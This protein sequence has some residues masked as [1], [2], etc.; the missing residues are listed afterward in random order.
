MQLVC[1]C[2]DS[3]YNISLFDSNHFIGETSPLFCAQKVLPRCAC[4][5]STNLT[6]R[7]RTKINAI[8]SVRSYKI[9]GYFHD[10][11]ILARRGISGQNAGY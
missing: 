2:L 1:L 6:F 3:R 7:F 11:G 8:F 10:L 5:T 4:S 9:A